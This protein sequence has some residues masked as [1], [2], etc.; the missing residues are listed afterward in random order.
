MTKILSQ[1]RNKIFLQILSVTA[2]LSL[3]I[4]SLFAFI[5]LTSFKGIL[6]EH[7]EEMEE[8]LEDKTFLE[9][10]H[11]MFYRAM[12]NLKNQTYLVLGSSIFLAIGSSFFISSRLTRNLRVL[13]K[14]IEQVDS[15][16]LNAK[17]HIR[18]KDEFQV[19]AE[20]L[21]KMLDSVKTKQREVSSEK[22]V[23]ESVVLNLS[24]GVVMFNEGGRINIINKTAEK[25]LQV[26]KDEI[27]NQ[28]IKDFST[29][30]NI[31]RLYEIMG[32]SI[33]KGWTDEYLSIWEGEKTKVYP[34]KANSV[35]DREGNFWGFLAIIK[36]V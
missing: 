9:E 25:I 11:E 5:T 15:G 33:E 6:K 21:A 27:V 12:D 17:I 22:T 31:S 24:D 32:R 8:Y 13:T 20:H 28:N 1:F 10:T 3:V 26:S 23:M 19:L 18:S 7:L 2:L 14:F 4:F 35:V 36:N 16:D 29:T 30:H 34:V